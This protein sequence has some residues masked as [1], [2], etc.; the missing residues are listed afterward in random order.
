MVADV[1]VVGAPLV[2]TAMLG[3]ALAISIME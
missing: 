1:L 3:G 2:S